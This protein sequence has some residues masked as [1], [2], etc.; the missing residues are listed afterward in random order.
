MQRCLI[1]K[2]LVTSSRPYI[3]FITQFE[4]MKRHKMFL[5]DIKGLVHPKMNTFVR[6]QNTNDIF[7]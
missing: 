1:V 2:N 7:D 6:L 5:L 4:G 3:H